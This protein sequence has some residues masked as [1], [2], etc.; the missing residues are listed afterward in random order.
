MLKKNIATNQEKM[1]WSIVKF[2]FIGLLLSLA[3]SWYLKDPESNY[4]IQRAWIVA[5]FGGFFLSLR[6]FLTKSKAEEIGEQIAL[7]TNPK[8][9]CLAMWG[10]LILRIILVFVFAPVVS[11][12]LLLKNFF[13]IISSIFAIKQDK[14]LFAQIQEDIK[15][16]P[17]V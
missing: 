13:R 16:D 2:I 7:F 14:K 12:W 15:A 3:L 10:V 9:G 8:N 4:T 1:W 6:Y 17:Q 5:G 11:S